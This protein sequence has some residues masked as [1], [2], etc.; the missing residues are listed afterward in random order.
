[1]SRMTFTAFFAF[2][3]SF[4]VKCDKPFPVASANTIMIMPAKMI[5]VFIVE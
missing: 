5:I 1:M 4:W 3:G 2:F